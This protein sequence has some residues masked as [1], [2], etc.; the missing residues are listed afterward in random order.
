MQSDPRRTIIVR[1]A[2]SI[3][4]LTPLSHVR[5]L[6]AVKLDKQPPLPL[7]TALEVGFT[8]EFRPGDPRLTMSREPSIP[9]GN[10]V[11]IFTKRAYF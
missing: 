5:L 4:S 7:E 11:V 1:H 2:F 6:L 3:Y 10:S 9:A 8:A